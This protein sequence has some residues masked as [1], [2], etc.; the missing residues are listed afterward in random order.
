MKKF[1]RFRMEAY[2]AR[3]LHHHISSSEQSH[4]NIHT[5]RKKCIRIWSH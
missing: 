2:E 3:S 4:F 1:D 5:I